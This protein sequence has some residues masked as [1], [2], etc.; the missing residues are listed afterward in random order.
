VLVHGRLDLSAP[1][2]IPW[3]LARAWPDNAIRRFAT[4]R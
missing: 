1:V 2:D 3:R 4:R